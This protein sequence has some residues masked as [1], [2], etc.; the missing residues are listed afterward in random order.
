ML[1]WEPFL[2]WCGTPLD[3]GSSKVLVPLCGKTRDLL[4]LAGHRHQVLGVEFVE[5]A[6]QDFFRETGI[7]H[8]VENRS[9][10]LLYRFEEGEILVAPGRRA[11]N[12]PVRACTAVHRQW[13][14]WS[15]HR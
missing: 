10:G 9:G 13:H 6:V 11:H 7:E 14:G 4:Y 5:R 12:G 3:E 15:A 1:H 8:R 2:D